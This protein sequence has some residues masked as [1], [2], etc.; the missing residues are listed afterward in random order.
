MRIVI[1]CNSF[2][3]FPAIDWLLEQ[4]AVAGFVAPLALTDVT[5]RLSLAAERRRLPFLM[6]NRKHI[7]PWVQE[8]RP[9]AVFVMTFPYRI[10]ESSLRVPPRGFF[11]FHPGLLPQYR[12][13]DPI[14][15]EIRNQEPQGAVTV[16]L[17]D[18]HFDTGPIAL[19]QRVEIHP[20]DNYHRHLEKLQEPFRIAAEKVLKLLSFAPSQLNLQQQDERL[21]GYYPKPGSADFAIQWNNQGA[22]AIAALTRA[23][24]PWY[25]GATTRFRDMTIHFSHVTVDPAA[26]SSEEPGAILSVDMEEGISVA[27]TGGQILRIRTAGPAGNFL[28]GGQFAQVFRMT[29]GEK[30]FSSL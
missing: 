28:P 6:A 7:D 16:H 3:A 27:C 5:Y 23:C 11:N 19:Q 24:Y 25:G 22:A 20:E 15:W 9:D 1:L 29:P 4:G 21:A 26:A 14:F 18:E 2:V 10:P 8:I 30:F 13:A 12:G 17:M